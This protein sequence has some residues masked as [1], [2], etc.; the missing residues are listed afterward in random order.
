MAHHWLASGSSGSGQNLVCGGQTNRLDHLRL[1]GN[2]LPGQLDPQTKPR[3]P[4]SWSMQVKALCQ[5][6]ERICNDLIRL[7]TKLTV[8]GWMVGCAHAALK[9]LGVSRPVKEPG[10]D[11]Q[12]TNLIPRSPCI[13]D[14]VN[15]ALQFSR[16]TRA[17]IPC[18][19][20]E[21]AQNVDGNLMI[22][23]SSG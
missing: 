3:H 16:S 2:L 4:A 9:R 15:L 14:L 10:R 8:E 12:S 6:P 18:A 17:M 19:L 22:L 5:Y 23:G 1:K 20:A 21:P 11:A 13:A 7:F